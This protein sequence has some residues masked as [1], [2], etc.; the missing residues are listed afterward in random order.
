MAL[1][2]PAAPVTAAGGGIRFM[3]FRSA[4]R[5]PHTRW[6][7]FLTWCAGAGVTSA[8]DVQPLHGIAWIESQT[9]R[10]GARPSSSGWP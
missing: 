3:E 8:T 4:I 5:H 1:T 6:E 10:H 2:S 7:D 9:L